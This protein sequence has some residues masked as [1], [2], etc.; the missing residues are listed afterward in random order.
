M[1]MIDISIDYEYELAYVKF[2]R[3]FSAKTIEVT[4]AINLD[5]DDSG[6]VIGVEFLTLTEFEVTRDQLQNEL[7]IKR[8]DV[9]EAVLEG[10]KLLSAKLA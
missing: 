10:Q 9:I 7:K 4:S 3:G 5:I 2:R 6:E 8:A 1:L